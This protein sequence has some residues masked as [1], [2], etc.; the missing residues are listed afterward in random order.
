MIKKF[1]AIL[2]FFVT[3]SSNNKVTTYSNLASENSINEISMILK[4]ELNEESVD[5][6]IKHVR[7]YN[8]I[9]ASAGLVSDF[10]EFK[11]PSYD[12]DKINSLWTS[13]K[14]DF[15]GTNCRINSY[16]LLKNDIT[17]PNLKI[18]DTFLFLDKH[19]I[20]K[21]NLFTDKDIEKFQILYSGVKTTATTDV[22]THAK[23]MQEY[24]SQ[25]KFNEKVRMISVVLHDN[26]D[27]D[28]LFVGHVGVMI[29]YDKGYLFI[30]KLSFEEPYQAI[31]FSTKEKV[32]KYLLDKY[33]HYTG[34]DLAVPFIMDNEKWVE[35]SIK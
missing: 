34:E 14:G 8:E 32:Y 26:V 15:I 13:K 16:M 23:K 29:P 22:K 2:L 6:F 3:V 31:K 1:L 7:E 5:K 20:D 9:V 25:I 10:V 18:D 21:G 4:K 19:A 24:F 17:I 28:Y 35:I 27:G 33:A 30:E 12:I 11:T